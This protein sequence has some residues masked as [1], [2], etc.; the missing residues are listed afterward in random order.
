MQRPISSSVRNCPS[1]DTLSVAKISSER[2]DQ[3]AEC[4][5]AAALRLPSVQFVRRSR[6]TWSRALRK[7]VALRAKEPVVPFLRMRSAGRRNIICRSAQDRKEHH[8]V[9]GRE[10]ATQLRASGTDDEGRRAGHW[11]SPWQP[12]KAGRQR[13]V[14]SA[15]PYPGNRESDRRGGSSHNLESAAA[16]VVQSDDMVEDLA[17]AASH[18]ALC[19]PILPRCLNTRALRLQ[20]GRRC[21]HLKDNEAMSG[22]QFVTKAPTD[23]AAGVSP[24]RLDTGAG[25]AASSKRTAR[26]LS[27]PTTYVYPSKCCSSAQPLFAITRIVSEL[28]LVSP[29]ALTPA[30]NETQFGVHSLE[31]HL[32]STN[33]VAH[34][35]PDA[36]SEIDRRSKRGSGDAWAIIGTCESLTHSPQFIGLS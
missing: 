12:A 14:G 32:S 10:L 2:D 28:R 20:T 13:A 21:R 34:F 15:Y 4:D 3:C 23:P 16:D 35:S 24:D 29:S 25:R 18:P 9:C 22:I 17:A 30:S 1:D 8:R 19:D 5:N 36:I 27:N 6:R 31:R 7:N 33:S 11:R 26:R